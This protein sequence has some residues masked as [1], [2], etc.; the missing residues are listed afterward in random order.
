MLGL[1]SCPKNRQQANDAARLDCARPPDPQGPLDA[2]VRCRLLVE[3]Y[4]FILVKTPAV[5][6]GV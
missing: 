3:G 4:R 2:H 5:M 1:T 6:G